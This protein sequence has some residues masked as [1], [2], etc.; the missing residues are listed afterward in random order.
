MSSILAHLPDSFR[1]LKKL[2]G[3]IIMGS[4]LLTAAEADAMHRM[5]SKPVVIILL[6]PPGAG[7]G[8]HAAPLSEALGLPH[9]STG[10]LFRMHI[11]QKTQLGLLAKTYIDQGNLVPDDLVL[12]MLFDRLKESD[13]QQGLILDGF[14]RTLTQAKS[15]DARLKNKSRVLALNFYVPD[16]ILIERIAGRL[17][18]RDCKRPYHKVFD[19]PQESGVCGQCGGELYMRE[20]DREEIV[21]KRLEVYRSETLPLIEYYQEKEGVLVEIDGQ[22]DKNQV[23]HDVLEALPHYFHLEGARRKR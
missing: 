9:I 16:S 19:P 20:D 1:R 7:K 4:I 12:D 17:I 13:C 8:T 22:N 6:G 21:R 2:L 11:Q 23:F 5:A 14:P 15:L 3:W 10:D 18:C